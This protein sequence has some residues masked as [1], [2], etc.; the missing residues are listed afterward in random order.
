[1]FKAMWSS[2]SSQ[3]NEKTEKRS[4]K[5]RRSKNTKRAK[6]LETFSAPLDMNDLELLATWFIPRTTE[7]QSG[8]VF[9]GLASRND[10]SELEY[11]CIWLVNLVTKESSSGSLPSDVLA[12]VHF[13]I[14]LIRE[15]LQDYPAAVQSF[16]NCLFL[17]S[18]NQEPAEKVAKT[19]YRLGNSYGR[20]GKAK[21]KKSNWKRAFALMGDPLEPD[22]LEALC[23]RRCMQM[24]EEETASSDF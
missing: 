4:T 11:M 12:E 16:V 20:I 22:E 18:Q 1:M 21:E 17:Q 2:R 8:L 6:L 19:L 3:S 23:S 7:D 9:R 10:R 14:G 13:F 15:E 5:S 24:V